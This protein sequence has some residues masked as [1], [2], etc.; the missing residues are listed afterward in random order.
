M[1]I[2][3][4]LTS[5]G[6]GGAERQA[7]DLAERMRER[8]H[9]VAVFTLRPQLEQEWPTSLPVFRLGMRK[10]PFSVCAA[11]IRA[12][13]T[14]R[15]LSPDLIH[16]HG[17]HANLFARL[18]AI[19]LPRAAIVSTIHNVYEGGRL[20]MVAYRLSDGLCART[21]AVSEAVARRFVA[22]KAVPQTR[23]TV[24]RNA[25]DMDVL[26][27]EPARRV[28]MREA[29][30]SGEDFIWLAAGRLAP[31]K[32]Y[33]N[34]LRAFSKLR[35]AHPGAQLWIAGQGTESAVAELENLAKE[36]GVERRT[37]FLGLRRDLP[38]LLDA[39]D[40][41]VLSSAWEGMPLGLGEAMAMA[42]PVVATDVGGVRELAGAC[43]RLVARRDSTAL[44]EAMD[45]VM[46]E[47]EETRRASGRAARMRIE[48]QFSAEA[49]AEEWEEIYCTVMRSKA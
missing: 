40:G 25:I 48:A 35:P 21:T 5:L 31:A 30:G 27:P 43:A 32:D 46:R 47:P 19:S 26:V 17:F 7:L 10:D 3:H 2:V 44:T 20:R 16:S 18:L 12:R 24:V 45:A 34:L 22:L 41:F 1:R 49:R 6:I 42:K 9:S 14:L 39:A 28:K 29:L 15:D 33:P 13:R 36:L 8:G 11:V 23:C 38:A 4:L 37:R